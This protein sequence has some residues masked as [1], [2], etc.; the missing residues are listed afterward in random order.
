MAG[1]SPRHNALGATL[2]AELV[3]AFRGGPCR[4]FT[5]DQRICLAPGAHYVY[6]DASVRG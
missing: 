3:A 6:A 2:I 4:V 5:A 1:G